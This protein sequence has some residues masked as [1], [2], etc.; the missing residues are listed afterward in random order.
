MTARRRADHVGCH[1]GPL[2]STNGLTDRL[3]HD[4]LVF[5][6]RYPATHYL[7]AYEK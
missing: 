4:G 7:A 6:T 3:A 1:C 5:R 2:D